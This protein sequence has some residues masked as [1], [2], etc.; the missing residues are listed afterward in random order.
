VIVMSEIFI[1][2]VSIIIPV[3]NGAN[4]LS[5]AIDSALSQTYKNIE[6]IVVNDGSNDDGATEGIAKQYGDKIRYY[7][8]P[9]GGV[10]SALNL[11]I[12]KMTGDYFSWLSHDDL[13]TPEKI[14][15]SVDV[16]RKNE[17][18][19]NDMIVYTGGVLVKADRTR[20]KSL[21][22]MLKSNRIYTGIEVVNILTQKG[23]LY[24]CC[25]LIPKEV[26]NKIGG[27][28]ESLR[29][30]QDSLMW[31]QI[32]LRGYYAYAC[33]QKDVLA[34]VH[35]KQVTNTHKYLFQSDIMYVA[36]K[37]IPIFA[38]KENSRTL[39]Y[40]YIKRITRLDCEDTVDY[41]MMYAKEHNIFSVK[42]Q[43][44]LF[45]EREIG[46]RIS[47]MKRSVKKIIMR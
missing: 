15:H 22:K 11:G 16:L 26:L 13:Y 29:Y 5:E 47:R 32:F 27:F 14:E 40:N 7:V 36:K 31:Y 44:K 17:K 2:K 39:F 41:W 34:R 18:H 9:N 10:S 35:K 33:P 37:L 6:I 24:G 3:Y 45:I 4:F 25:L 8:K 30:C 21:H 12:Q 1:P 28:E 43:N 23:T 19:R 42:E 38:T 20:I 46:K